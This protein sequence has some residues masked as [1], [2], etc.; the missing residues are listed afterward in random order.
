MAPLKI[1]ITPILNEIGENIEFDLEESASFPE[2]DLDLSAPLKI[3]GSVM[4][5]GQTLLLKG[6]VS[7]KIKAV[8]GRCLEEFSCPL[9]FDVEE[10]FSPGKMIYPEEKDA[11]IEEDDL[12]FEIDKDNTIDLLEVIRQNIITEIPIKLLCPKETKEEK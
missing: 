7:T 10:E 11:E 2:D 4:N 5:T 6:R 8:C 3:K 12:L 1:D 9:E